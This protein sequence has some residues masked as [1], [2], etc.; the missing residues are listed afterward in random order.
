M[1]EQTKDW[2]KIEKTE[3]VQHKYDQ[4]IF[5]KRAKKYNGAKTVFST[6]SDGFGLCDACLYSWLLRR[7]RQENHNFKVNPGKVS[8]LE[9]PYLKNKVKTKG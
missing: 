9:R 7:Q 4:L 8:K 5:D 6:N 3:I 1:N 2:M